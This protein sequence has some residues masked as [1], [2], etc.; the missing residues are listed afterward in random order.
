MKLKSIVIEG[1]HNVAEKTYVFD[2]NL[3]Y[4]FGKNGA[5]KTTAL[6]AIQLAL[7][8]YIP[9]QNKTNAAIFRHAKSKAM[10]VTANLVAADGQNIQIVRSWI[11][12]GSSVAT[13]VTVTPEGY[14]LEQ[15][16]GELELPIYNFNEFVNMTANKLKEWFIQ[17]LP[18]SG[19]ALDWESKLTEALGDMQVLDETLLPGLLDEIS[20]I[21]GTGM[22]GVELVQ[23]VNTAI[24]SRISFNKGQAD[25]LT[26]TVQSLIYYDD[27]DA[28]LD[29]ESLKAEASHLTTL[30]ME[31][32]KY[33]GALAA[34]EQ[35]LAA[36]NSLETSAPSLEEDEEYKSLCARV[37]ELSAEIET[38]SAKYQEV[39]ANIAVLKSNISSKSQLAVGNG[40]CPYTKSQCESIVKMIDD[41]KSEVVELNTKLEKL[42]AEGQE[43]L[44]KVNA[45]NA[46]KSQAN[47]RISTIANIYQRRAELAAQI[48]SFN[49]VEPTSKTDEELAAEIQNIQDKITK[50]E[51]NKRYNEFTETLTAQKYV[52]ESAT[53]ALKI[54]EK[55]TGANGLQTELMVKPFES[56]ADE[57]TKFLTVVFNNPA[58]VAKF[59]L[60]EKANSFSF[61]LERDGKYIPF[62]LLSSGEKCLYTIA[63]MMCLTSKSSSPLKLILIDDLLDH[64]DDENAKALFESLS[65]TDEVQFIL[66]G[67]KECKADNASALVI[68]VK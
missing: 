43:Y 61:G 56:L 52:I 1:M 5:G 49:L 7:L 3:S 16:I 9:G 11:A 38:E 2:S 8:G 50:A 13:S 59:N 60:S 24:K 67:V 14:N 54:W 64:L 45:A 34:K 62:D 48:E 25:R 31:L 20:S 19:D 63:L 40:V 4:L 53:A 58:V 68:E 33:S 27:G 39:N 22:S 65:R 15:I 47:L 17:F 12:S 6:E 41:V 66:A 46:E 18:N 26:S 36:L 30:R 21:A 29:V 42:A 10:V 32:S 51:A 55:L 35:A 37:S 57:M 23:A 28:S 44:G